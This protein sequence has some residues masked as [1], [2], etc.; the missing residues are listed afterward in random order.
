M[1]LLEP[2]ASSHF[3]PSFAKSFRLEQIETVARYSFQFA[4]MALRRLAVS[5]TRK[6]AQDSPNRASGSQ[7]LSIFFLLYQ[8]LIYIIVY[9]IS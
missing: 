3:F 7:I 4:G 5:M 6:T 2:K 9:R 1:S 8:L